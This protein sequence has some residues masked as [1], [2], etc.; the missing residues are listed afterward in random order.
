M[1]NWTEFLVDD[2][3]LKGIFG[4]SIV[5]LMNV[6]I[7]EVMMHRNGP[8]V[9]LRFDLEDFPI[10]PPKKWRD[11]NFNTVQMTLSCVDVS[12]LSVSGLSTTMNADLVFERLNDKIQ[13]HIQTERFN[14]HLIC[15]FL[16]IE[17]ISAYVDEK[18]GLLGVF[19]NVD[20]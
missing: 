13:L 16:M 20:N 6:S 9:T 4:D 10:E 18:E 17:S 5:S 8:A 1:S 3:Q 14:L 11:N 7:H 15:N 19:K 12:N 2:K